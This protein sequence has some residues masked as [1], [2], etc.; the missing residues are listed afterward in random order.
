MNT[1]T[2][3]RRTKQESQDSFKFS[4]WLSK[5]RN[6]RIP[7]PCCWTT[8]LGE[9]PEFPTSDTECVC[10]VFKLPLSTGVLG[11]VVA[12]HFGLLGFTGKPYHAAIL[13]RHSMQYQVESNIFQTCGKVDLNTAFF[14]LVLVQLV[15]LGTI[16]G[17]EE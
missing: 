5:T 4:H 15:P 17:A 2:L 14:G 10:L 6:S 3:F 12:C 11:N 9:Q 16:P 13:Q 7:N 1:S 8:P